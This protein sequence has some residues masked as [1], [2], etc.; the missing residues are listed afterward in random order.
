MISSHPT[1]ALKICFLHTKIQ[2][3]ALKIKFPSDTLLTEEG[4]ILI[5]SEVPA[6]T[7]LKFQTKIFRPLLYL[8]LLQILKLM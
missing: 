1:S 3:I 4:F 6:Q 5:F 2:W 8:A 7:G